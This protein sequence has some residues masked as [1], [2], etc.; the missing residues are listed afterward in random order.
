MYCLHLCTQQFEQCKDITLEY[1]VNCYHESLIC[2]FYI[3]LI[4]SLISLISITAPK[5][6]A[7]PI[8]SPDRRSMFVSWG[9]LK[10]LAD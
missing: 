9:E 10:L 2:L 3:V 8:L 6:L 7:A 5:F 1:V 4:F